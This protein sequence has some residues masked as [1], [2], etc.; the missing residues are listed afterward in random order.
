[1]NKDFNRW[2]FIEK[3]LP[4]Y[5]SDQDVAWSTTCQN[6]LPENTTIKTRMTEAVSML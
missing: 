5:S 3:W 6:I 2:E 1:M 4:N